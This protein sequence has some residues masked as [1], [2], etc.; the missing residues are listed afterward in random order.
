MT[1]IAQ[2]GPSGPSSSPQSRSGPSAPAVSVL[3][4]FR[5]AASTLARCLDSLLA[6]TDPDFEI[7]AVDD[8]SSD[9][10][11]AIAKSYAAK[12]ARLRVLTRPPQGIVTAL[13]AGLAACRGRIVARMDADD[14]AVPT[15]LASQRAFLKAHP[16]IDLLGCLAEPFADPEAA[17]EQGTPPTGMTRYHY[18]MNALRDD[19]S[20]KREL[21]VESPIAH[22]TF[23]ARRDFFRGLWG[24]RDLPWPEDYDL[25][26]RAAE[27]GTIFGKVPEMLVWRGSPPDRLTRTDPRYRREGMFKAKATFLLR[28]PWLKTN[29][30]TSGRETGPREIVIGGSGTS[31]RLAARVLA[32]AGAKVRC[33]LDNRVGPPGRRVMGLPAHGWPDEIPAAF[34]DQHR[35]AFFISCIG[36]A[37]GRERLRSHLERNGFSEGRDWL[38]FA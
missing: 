6:Q 20:I 1:G 11:G 3:L 30:E 14:V 9:E 8:G 22:P 35:D 24:Y 18:W 21:F 29:A 5:D 19:E 27:R 25:L 33:F 4:P 23:F 38:R 28:G 16:E 26:L 36:A 17:G 37:E 32:E 2:S 10:G 12:D 13:N 31:G 7:V 34:F 15:R